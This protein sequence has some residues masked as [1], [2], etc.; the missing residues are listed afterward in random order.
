VSPHLND[1]GNLAVE[2]SRVELIGT[3]WRRSL[4]ATAFRF[5]PIGIR[6]FSF[7]MRYRAQQLALAGDLIDDPRA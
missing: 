5:E 6:E 1:E 2:R 4:S 7:E 3:T